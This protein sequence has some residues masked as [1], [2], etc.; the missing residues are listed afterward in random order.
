MCHSFRQHVENI[1]DSFGE[2]LTIN[3]WKYL[4]FVE[5]ECYHVSGKQNKQHE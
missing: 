2:H 4:L 5:G 1:C 3:V